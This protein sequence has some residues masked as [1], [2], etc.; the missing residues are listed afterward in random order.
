[1]QNIH[2]GYKIMS[3]KP[4]TKRLYSCFNEGGKRTRWTTGVWKK[5]KG[6]VVACKNALHCAPPEIGAVGFTIY[7]G[8]TSYPV[9]AIVEYGGELSM[10]AAVGTPVNPVEKIAAQF[11]R[12]VGV[13]ELPCSRYVDQDKWRIAEE[14]LARKPISG[15]CV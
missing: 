3:R 11:M 9:L 4:G 8:I 6:K 5:V 15:R 2:L 12:V 1:M 10:K 13:V 14:F 7:S